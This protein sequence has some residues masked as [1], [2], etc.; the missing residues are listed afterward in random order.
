MAIE[1]VSTADTTTKDR[2]RKDKVFTQ[3]CWRI[4]NTLDARLKLSLLRPKELSEA[5][6]KLDQV[7]DGCFVGYEKFLSAFKAN[8]VPKR[9]ED[10]RGLHDEGARRKITAKGSGVVLYRRG[11]LEDDEG[12]EDHGD[13]DSLPDQYESYDSMEEEEEDDL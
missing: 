5:F 10:E 3:T 9:K 4:Y 7:R 1:L 6:D 12:N 13:A 8:S 2:L 11:D